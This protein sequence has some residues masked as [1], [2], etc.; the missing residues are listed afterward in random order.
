MSR[1][2]YGG[3]SGVSH[4]GIKLYGGVNNLSRNV[5]KGYC[6]VGG[7]SRQFWPAQKTTVGAR[8]D[9][10]PGGT[11]ELNTCL[12]EMAVRY[13]LE[14]IRKVQKPLLNNY[15]IYSTYRDKIDEIL[16][17]FLSN[18]ADNNIVYITCTANTV[19]DGTFYINIYLGKSASLNRQIDQ[20][21]I[22][23]RNGTTYASLV[24]NVTTQKTLQY[25]INLTTKVFTKSTSSS[26]SYFTNIGVEIDYG[27]GGTYGVGHRIRITNLGMTTYS[28][29]L[30]ARGD[31]F[32]HFDW[33]TG[34]YDQIDHL[35]ATYNNGAEESTAIGQTDYL[36]LPAFLWEPGRT[37]KVKC[38]DFFSYWTESYD[39]L[40]IEDHGDD[41]HY[42]YR[43]EYA[44]ESS[45]HQK[46]YY[47]CY[48]KIYPGGGIAGVYIS[49]ASQ[50]SSHKRG[51]DVTET[52]KPALRNNYV[53]QEGKA[54]WTDLSQYE[55][56]GEVGDMTNLEPLLNFDIDIETNSIRC[57]LGMDKNY[58][59]PI[60]N[61]DYF[62]I[63]NYGAGTSGNTALSGYKI[64]EIEV[65]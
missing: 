52:I 48:F 18:L 36:Q 19:G 22:D 7:V 13:A 9:L 35:L 45:D 51:F 14:F 61:R 27:S 58:T 1:A 6:G 44:G 34:M 49:N 31:W 12:P 65:T 60:V 26:I 23:R 11:Y 2:A 10:N 47:R 8:T 40:A 43:V 59:P 42:Y 30:I 64:T 20:V 38:E 4:K 46:H 53:E 5:I 50:Y 15:G 24:D 3:A 57:S 29:E 55:D 39:Y 41:F 37:I 63:G 33:H 28:V 17:D 25:T 21:S 56:F 32:W 54:R 62:R 16:A